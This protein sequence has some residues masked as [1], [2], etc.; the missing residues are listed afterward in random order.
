MSSP[1]CR[2]LPGLQSV[3]SLQFQTSTLMPRHISGHDIGWM[4]TLCC[5]H[6]PA[7]MKKWTEKGEELFG[8]IAG[9]SAYGIKVTIRLPMIY[10][11]TLSLAAYAQRESRRQESLSIRFFMSFPSIVPEEAPI[12]R[13]SKAGDVESMMAM[14]EARTAAY[15]DITR[16]GT[17]LLHVRLPRNSASGNL[18]INLDCCKGRSQEA[19]E[20]SASM[21]RRCKCCG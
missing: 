7:H 19:S 11:R 14:F 21:R 13:A 4:A 10:S 6:G 16:T 20:L 5:S 8:V 15:T 9:W 3:A 18:L 2:V 17:C 12:M 1:S